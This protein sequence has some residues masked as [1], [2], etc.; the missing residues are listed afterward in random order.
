MDRDRHARPDQRRRASGLER[1]HV[2]RSERGPP[3]GDGQQ[4]EVEP[5][6]QP[7]HALEQLRVAREVDPGVAPDEVTERRGGRTGGAHG[8][9][10]GEPPP[11]S[12]RAP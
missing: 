5:G 11:R 12:P 10:H 4:G 9:C 2:A 7:G 3:A 8:A 1:V 6:G